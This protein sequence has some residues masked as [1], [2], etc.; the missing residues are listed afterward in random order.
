M[1]L[2]RLICKLEFKQSGMK[3]YIPADA[4]HGVIM[5]RIDAD[6]AHELHIQ[7]LKPYSQYVESRKDGFA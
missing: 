5:E 2:Q 7:S 1:E 6:S 4:L 3:R